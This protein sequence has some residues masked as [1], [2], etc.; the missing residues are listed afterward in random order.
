[1]DTEELLVHDG[2]QWQAVKRLHTGIIHLLS[3]LDLTCTC[4]YMWITYMYMTCMD[5][6]SY[7]K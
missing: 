5:M 4:M 1:M 3:V 2:C 7:T 6:Y